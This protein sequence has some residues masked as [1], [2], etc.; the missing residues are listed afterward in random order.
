MK[1]ALHFVGFKDERVWNARKT[2]GEPDFWH[3][4]W[5]ERVRREIFEGDE[6]IFATGDEN[7]PLKKFTWND[8]ERF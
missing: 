1:Q 5:D 7:Q 3:R 6:V 4:V 2:F 8:S